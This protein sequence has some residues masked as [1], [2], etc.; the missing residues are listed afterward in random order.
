M[1]SMRCRHGARL[2]TRPCPS[3]ASSRATRTTARGTPAPCHAR[4]SAKSLGDSVCSVPRSLSEIGLDA[5]DVAPKLVVG[6]ITAAPRRTVPGEGAGPPRPSP[7]PRPLARAPA[8]PT[9]SSP[10]R[11]R[12]TSGWTR[13]WTFRLRISGAIRRISS[14]I[15]PHTVAGVLDHPSAGAVRARL[16]K[17]PFQRLLDPLARE[18]DEAELV[19]REN[20]R[21]RAIRPKLLLERGKNLLTALPLLHV[22]EVDDDDAAEIAQAGSVGRSP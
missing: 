20:L 13:S 15:S 4:A 18:D 14:K 6:T 9:V 2:A 3:K 11:A 21:R 12:A 22:D 10:A 17:R 1:R 19:H 8:A 7:R 5:L 16:A